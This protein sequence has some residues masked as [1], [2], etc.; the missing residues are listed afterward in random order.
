MSGRALRRLPVLVLARYISIGQT[1][2]N[3]NPITSTNMQPNGHPRGLSANLDVW[4]D[5]M[6]RVIIEQANEHGRLL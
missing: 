4:L 5:M 1:G 2:S 6:E 3:D